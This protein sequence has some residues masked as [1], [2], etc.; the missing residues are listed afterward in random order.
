M[1]N[2]IANGNGDSRYMKSA[3]PEDITHEE[4]VALLRKG[5]FPFDFN[6]INRD[7]FAQLG[8]GLTKENLLDDNTETTIWGNAADRT[9]NQALYKLAMSIYAGD[10]MILNITVVADSGEPISG[11]LIEGV[12]DS[13]ANAIFT[14]ANGKA[15]GFTVS[16]SATLTVSGYFDLEDTTVTV[17]GDRGSTQD[18]TITMNRRNFL[19]ITSSQKKVFSALCKRVD[20]SCV[21]GGG[22]GGGTATNHAYNRYKEAYGAGGGGGYAST[23]ENVEFESEVEYTATVGAGGTANQH[24]AGGTGG[25]SSFLGVS[26][27]GGTGGQYIAYNTTSFTAAAGNGNGGVGCAGDES[28]LVAPTAGTQT[29]FSSFTATKKVGG[30]GGAGDVDDDALPTHATGASPY[31]GNGGQVYCW[32][33]INRASTAGKAPGGGGG[34][35]ASAEENTSNDSWSEFAAP[36]KGGRGEINIR[37][38]FEEDLAA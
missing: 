12:Y 17:T 8:Q 15:S 34:G 24:K 1:R 19:S 38:W 18:A 22:G 20:V 36:S 4:L 21:G 27:K 3:I 9:V 31:G 23:Q 13:S 11:A 35:G 7:G 25:T 29:T 28:M 30:G 26:A 33:G 6:G 37:M 14:D 16:T 32:D 10:G 2:S 5:T